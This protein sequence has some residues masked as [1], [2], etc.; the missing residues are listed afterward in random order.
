[1]GDLTGAGGLDMSTRIIM[2]TSTTITYVSIDTKLLIT[3][4]DLKTHL[5]PKLEGAACTILAT[6]LLFFVSQL[7]IPPITSFP[8]LVLL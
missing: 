8:V 3:E 4:L 7:R 2:P 5:L 6:I 1:M